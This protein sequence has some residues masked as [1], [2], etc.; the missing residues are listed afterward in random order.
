MENMRERLI[1]MEDKRRSLFL[2][3]VSLLSQK[4]KWYFRRQEKKRMQE[5]G[6]IKKIIDLKFK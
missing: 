4:C 6:L 1:D 3:K 5:G 2:K